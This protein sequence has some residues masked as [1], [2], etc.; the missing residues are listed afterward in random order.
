VYRILRPLFPFVTLLTWALPAVAQQAS[1]PATIR[2]IVPFAVAGSTDV[3]ARSVATELAARLKTTVIVENRA[4]AGSLI[5][6][7]AVA[8]GPKDGSMLLFTTG[9][10]ATAVATA[11]KLSFDATG[12][13][14]S[15]AL[16][17]EGPM[18]IAVSTSSGIKTPAELIAVARAKPDALTYGSAGVGSISHL[19]AELIND[20]AKVKTRHI[21]YK[22]TSQ[23]LVDLAAGTLDWTV[24]TYTTLIPQIQAGRVRVIGVTTPQANPSFPGV[25][26]MASA[27][28]GFDAST[29]IAVF[30]PKG[31]PAALVQRYNR[32]F[33]EIAKVKAL[34]DQMSADG[35]VRTEWTPEQA[36]DKVRQSIA[37]WKRIA[38]EK[39][40]FTE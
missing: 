6:S 20:S 27:V 25:L 3:M 21:P 26:P 7:D 23:A 40:I 2:L 33:N 29:W 19:A 14:Q 10:F 28:P 32:E 5:G 15:V 37:L 16:I 24:A 9:S 18:V 36:Q 39:S 31:T 22:G 1:V 30:A 13:L 4:G 12:D 8:K 17:G 38:S 35:L 34:T 11:R